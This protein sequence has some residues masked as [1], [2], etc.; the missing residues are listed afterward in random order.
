MSAPIEIV[1]AVLDGERFISAFLESLTA[2]THREWRLWVRDD[3]SSDRTVDILRDASASDPRINVLHVG[4]PRLG[5]PHAFG[6]A[7]QRVPEDASYYMTADADDVWLPNKIEVSLNALRAAESEHGDGTPLLVHT[8]LTVVDSELRLRAHSFWQY[9]NIDPRRTAIRSLSIRNVV[10]GQTIMMN[11]ALKRRIGASPPGIAKHD[12]WYALVA[13]ACGR[14]V[15]VPESTVLYRQHDKNDV[16]AHEPVKLGPTNFVRAA[17]TAFGNREWFRR[18]LA[19]SAIQARELLDGYGADLS[20][21]DR[22]FLDAFAKLPELGPV[23]RKLG[24]LQ[25]WPIPERG[26]IRTLGAA[27]RI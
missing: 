26:L 9:M 1:C 25:L 27:A 4:G 3:G 16:G 7:L 12:W 10:A 21:D 8:D 22:R 19:I 20:A 18:E 13:A 6:W 17:R 2:Q 23:R 5:A 14:I 15:A 11:A 24:L